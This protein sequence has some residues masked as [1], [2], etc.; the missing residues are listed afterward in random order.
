MVWPHTR[1]ADFSDSP[2]NARIAIVGAGLGGLCLAQNLRRRGIEAHVFERDKSPWERP[3]G[4]RLHLDADGINALHESLG[5]ELYRL[6]DA[7]S[8]KPAPFTTIVDTNLAVRMRRSHDD[9]G[10]TSASPHEGL[11]AHVN[12][13]R[14]TL[15]EVLLAGL[16]GHVHFDRKLVALEEHDDVV[17]LKFDDGSEVVA[18]I[19]VGA[20]GIQS[21]VR[22]HRAPH[23]RTQDSGVRAVYGRIPF[24]SAATCL[25]R[26]ALEDVFTV[27]VDERQC[28]L[29]LGPVVFPTRP[30]AAAAALAPSARM[31]P[32]EDYVV[33]IIGGRQ[34]LFD[35]DDA[36][37]RTLPSTEL[38]ELASSVI[39]AWP[40]STR[41]IL[42]FADPQAFFWVE[43]YTSIPGTLP[44]PRRITLLGDAIHA[45]T[46]TLGRGANVALRDAAR[47]GSALTKAASGDMPLPLALGEYEA[48]MLA[49]GFDVVRTAAAMGTRLMG[50]TPLDE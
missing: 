3:Q 13:N 35:R 46:P 47:L 4:Y 20:D 21:A 40:D 37:C 16:D 49:Y 31:S 33:A 32:R 48:E 1:I 50:Q 17:A 24:S 25:P 7:T 29:G 38:R 11:P 22:T 27:A 6:F 30:E 43:M 12:V 41:R 8:M 9:H 45:M 39:G 19:V 10:G 36:E 14:A 26:Q 44:A 42:E 28:F 2:S 5:P 23:L 34:A 15:R 18:D